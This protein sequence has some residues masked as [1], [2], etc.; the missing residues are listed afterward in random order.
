[1]QPDNFNA[2]GM[3]LL[4]LG[5]LVVI[6]IAGKRPQGISLWLKRL[7]AAA[8]FG[9]IAYILTPARHVYMCDVQGLGTNQAM[10]AG[11]CILLIVIFV[12][13][14]TLAAISCIII[15]FSG[16]SLCSQYHYLVNKTGSYAYIDPMSGQP[17][18]YPCPDPWSKAIK[19]KRLWHSNITG[20]FKAE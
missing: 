14:I 1:M 8:F 3:I 10:L 6:A 7:F 20:I 13:K 9:F 11:L 12:P 18:N 2:I 5:T 16:C 4:L 15:T 19:A 17:Y